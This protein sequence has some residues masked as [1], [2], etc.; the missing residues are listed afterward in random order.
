M[1]CAVCL[2]LL[3]VVQVMAW[4]HQGKSHYL[5]QCWHTPLSP[6]H[7]EL[8]NDFS[9]TSQMQVYVFTQCRSLKSI[10]MMTSSN[11]RFF[12]VTGPCGGGDS[13][14]TGEFPASEAELWC[15]LCDLPLNKRLSKQSRRRWFE[16]PSRTLWRHCNVSHMFR[17]DNGGDIKSNQVDFSLG[18]LTTIWHKQS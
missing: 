8:I 14:V 15:F 13:P 4:C 17:R 11:G 12:C 18:T 10:Y 3:S 5:N 2:A 1:V 9:L 16:T 6:D 7:S